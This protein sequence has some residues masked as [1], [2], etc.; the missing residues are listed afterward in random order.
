MT[1]HRLLNIFYSS[2]LR[3]CPYLSGRRERIVATELTGASA[4]QLYEAGSSSG[5]RR[6]HNLLYRPACP[7]CDACVP[8][9]VVAKEF[10]ATRSM[11]RVLR[12]NADVVGDPEPRGDTGEA[13]PHANEEQY[14]V[15]ARYQRARHANGAMNGM[16][17]DD[18]RAMVE[19][20]PVATT[21][22]EFRTPRGS[23]LGGLLADRL[24]DGLSAVYS[25]FDPDLRK[26]GFGTYMVL[27][28]IER[29]KRL[30]LSYVYL[31]YWIADSPKMAYKTRFRPLE[32]LGPEGWRILHRAPTTTAT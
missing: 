11:R 5:F 7:R 9:R 28:L 21:L 18:Y 14:L 32:A 13:P 2:R 30:D 4:K 1:E 15:F 27:W 8:V 29:A 31:G 26:E 16:D 22:T 19:E 24:G 20:S 6:S 10:K 3:A 23:L 12:I 17:F 25:F